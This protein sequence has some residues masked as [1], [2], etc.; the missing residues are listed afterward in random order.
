MKEDFAGVYCILNNVNKKIYIGSSIHIKRRISEHKRALLNNRHENSHLQRAWNKYGENNFEFEVLEKYDGNNINELR[1]LEQYWMDWY[2]S[3]ERSRGYNIS[4]Y[5]EGSGGY[6]VSEETKQKISRALKG[7]PQ[8]KEVRMQRSLNSVGKLNSFYG[9]RHTDVSKE[10]MRKA[11][12]GSKATEKQLLA[13]MKS[14]GSLYY[15]ENSYQK[16]KE[17]NS[18]ENSATAKLTENDVI[19]IL[20]LL[21]NGANYSEISQQF[22]I[23][24]A[25]ICRIKKRE[26]WKCVYEKYPELYT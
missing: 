21:K 7:K 24:M 23:S 4:K 20:K 3:Y 16:L 25:Q 12:L 8:S 22:N 14:R 10:R 9:K 26:R 1:L 19:E 6:I 13:L 18:G 2:K 5:A 15:T 11:K 17:A